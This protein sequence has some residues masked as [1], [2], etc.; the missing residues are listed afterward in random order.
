VTQ[1]VGE[2]PPTVLPID[3]LHPTTSLP[4][5]PVFDGHP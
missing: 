4:H 2:P 5:R 3:E 1:P